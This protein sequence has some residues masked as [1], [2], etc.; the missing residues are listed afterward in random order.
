MKHES[1]WMIEK[2]MNV[3]CKSWWFLEI[4]RFRDG[5]IAG[6]ASP[7]GPAAPADPAVWKTSH[8]S[9]HSC[10]NTAFSDNAGWG[11]WKVPTQ[12]Q[13]FRKYKIC[14]ENVEI[15]L[16]YFALGSEVHSKNMNLNSWLLSKNVGWKLQSPFPKML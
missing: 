3:K 2:M 11:F 5:S 8:A 15:L 4:L 14:F 12:I 1:W 13:V 10:Y 9:F 6:P 7:A 16:S